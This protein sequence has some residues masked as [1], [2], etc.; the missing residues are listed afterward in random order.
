MRVLALNDDN[1]E[2]SF[3]IENGE[4]YTDP[5]TFM[6]KCLALPHNE[7]YEI[8]EFSIYD[9]VARNGVLLPPDVVSDLFDFVA[10]ICEFPYGIDISFE[11]AFDLLW[12]AASP[13]R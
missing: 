1:H 3:R 7:T 4:E 13:I 6:V 8:R 9:D 12:E 10:G 5:F 2:D 11:E